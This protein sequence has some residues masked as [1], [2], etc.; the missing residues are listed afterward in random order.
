ML[1]FYSSVLSRKLP[2]FHSLFDLFFGHLS[3]VL[4]AAEDFW[5]VPAAYELETNQ[6]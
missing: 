1:M 5:Y 4:V 2:N 3:L 6:K